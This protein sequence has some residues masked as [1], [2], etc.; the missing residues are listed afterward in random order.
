M[1]VLRSHPISMFTLGSAVPVNQCAK[2][3]V[4]PSNFMST[5]ATK[6][7]PT[8]GWTPPPPGNSIGEA[9]SSR[10]LWWI[11]G[12]GAVAGL[13]WIANREGALANPSKTWE[14]ATWERAYREALRAG[15]KPGEASEYAYEVLQ[16]ERD[17]QLNVLGG[18]LVPDEE[19]SN[20]PGRA[21]KLGFTRADADPKQ[22]QLGIK[23]ELEHTDSKKVAERIALDHL[24]ED[25]AY[26]SKLDAMERSSFRSNP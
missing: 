14:S 16:A 19:Y 5:G 26:Y 2:G 4:L 20:N 10:M 18:A 23:H 25:E 24:S 11:V 22:L 3:V 6:S 13:A 12:I 9:V 1:T 7:L 21:Q 8:G 15:F 17:D